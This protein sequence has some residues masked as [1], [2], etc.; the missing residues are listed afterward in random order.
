MCL[1]PTQ[2]K[3]ESD[4]KQKTTIRFESFPPTRAAGM[5]AVVFRVCIAVPPA[6]DILVRKPKVEKIAAVDE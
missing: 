1:P 2:L 3:A 6:A 4:K 5:D